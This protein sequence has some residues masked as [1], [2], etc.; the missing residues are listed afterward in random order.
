MALGMSE[1]PSLIDI[2]EDGKPS[3]IVFKVVST[4]FRSTALTVVFA[5]DP[6]GAFGNSH[7]WGEQGGDPT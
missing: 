3:D 2:S 5:L 4:S 7:V 1:G 6:I